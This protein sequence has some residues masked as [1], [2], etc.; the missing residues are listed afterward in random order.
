MDSRRKA[1]T[2][3]SKHLF[4]L[5]LYSVVTRFFFVQRR[6]ETAHEDTNNLTLMPL[7]S[8][9][10][11]IVLLFARAVLTIFMY[12]FT[13]VEMSIMPFA[14][15]IRTI[16]A[17]LRATTKPNENESMECKVALKYTLKPIPGA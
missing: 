14:L 15:R 6:V 11:F 3:E 10:V 1:Q 9:F 12:L 13:H 16:R 8:M 17:D 7:K 5:D 4:K 2:T